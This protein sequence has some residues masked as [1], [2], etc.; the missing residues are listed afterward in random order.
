M[1]VFPLAD[2]PGRTQENL[3]GQLLRKKLEPDVEDYIEQGRKLATATA[4][5]T[6]LNATD[7]FDPTSDAVR[8]LWSWAGMAANEQARKH[9]WQ[10]NYTREEREAGI[11]QAI[12]GLKRKLPLSDEEEYEEMSGDEEEGEDEEEEKDEPDPDEMDIVAVHRKETGPGVE[13]DLRS[14]SVHNKLAAR[15]GSALALND[16]FRFLLTGQM[17]PG[18]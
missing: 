18:R 3:L 15:E 5:T 10:A 8:E 7:T 13:F 4:T 12:T 1:A 2:F 9:I 6:T 11:E 14:D 17:P 16:H